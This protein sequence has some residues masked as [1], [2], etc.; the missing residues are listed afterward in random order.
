MAPD[1]ER[2]KS[3]VLVDGPVGGE[4]VEAG[5]RRGMTTEQEKRLVEAASVAMR[6]LNPGRGLQSE[7]VIR[8]AYYGL[9]EAL[10]PYEQAEIR[11]L[12][13][14]RARA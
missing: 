10:A 8:A 2:A 11:R 13:A 7:T 3:L 6:A 9:V 4:C 14:E 1:R 5:R 12:R